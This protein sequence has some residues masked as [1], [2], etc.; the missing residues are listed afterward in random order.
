MSRVVLLPFFLSGF[1]ALVYEVVWTRSLFHLLGGTSSTFA[2][3][4]VVF[5]VGLAIGGRVGGSRA[6]DRGSRLR[7]YALL[8]IVIAVF[9]AAP[10]DAFLLIGT[11]GAGSLGSAN[12]ASGLATGLQ[13]LLAAVY[14]LIPTVAMGATF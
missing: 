6:F 2:F 3:V 8:Q 10:C 7:W 4:L 1:A 14:L 9:G 12:G 11:V 13:L 5:T